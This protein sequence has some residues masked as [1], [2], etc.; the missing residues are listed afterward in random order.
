MI[1]KFPEVSTPIYEVELLSSKKPIKFR[2]FLVKEQKLMLMAVESKDPAETVKILK[3]VATNCIVDKTI[4]VD[5]L[6]YVDLELLFLNFR[7]RSMGEQ[8]N[9]YFKCKNKVHEE[10]QGELKNCGMVMEIPVNLL[11]VPVVNREIEKRIMINESVGVQMK[12]PTFEFMQSI[13][14]RNMGDEDG[15][16]KA[17]AMCVDYVFDSDNAYYAKDATTEEMINFLMTLPPEKY[18]DIENFFNNLPKVRKD[19]HH[20]CPKCSYEHDLKLEGLGDFFI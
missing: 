15:D 6:S 16:F 3:E 10:E 14:E 13:L 9:V 12:I 19:I 20:K 4:N 17:I 1:M 18:E 8:I 7:A 11:E 2:P 5:D